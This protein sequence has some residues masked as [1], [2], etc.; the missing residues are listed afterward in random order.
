MGF[1][2]S[3]VL[4]RALVRAATA[5]TL[6]SALLL[7]GCGAEDP[8]DAAAPDETTVPADDPGADGEAADAAAP[9]ANLTDGCVEDVPEGVDLFPEKVTFEHASGVVVTYHDTYKVVE[10]GVPYAEEGTPP[11]T[12]VLLQCGADAPEL[13][14]DLADAQVVEVPTGEIISMTTVNLPHLAA[15]DAVDH[16]AGVG[17]AAFVTTPEVV[18]AIEERGL[19]DHADADGV[20]DRE[21]IVGA[22]PDLLV[23][24]AFGATLLDDVRTFAE[25]GV[26]TVLNADFDEATPLGRAEWIKYTALFLNRE[27]AATEVFADIEAGYAETAALAE[28][29]EDRPRVLL[30]QP[31]EGTWYVPAGGSF[32]PQL[33]ADAGGDYVFAD[34]PGSASV[35]V[36]LEAVLARGGD[37]DVWI[38]AGTA[39][40]TLEDLAAVDGRF[41]EFRAFQEGAVWA[42]A[43]TPAGGYPLYEE[44][45]AR[46]DLVLRDLTAIL[47]PELVEGHEVRFYV[48]LGEAG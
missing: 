8:S 39:G 6:A 3:P 11:F 45:A 26:P 18:A 38:G 37:A 23:L 40:G 7:S 36:D 13:T 4:P 30:E 34:E 35:S 10:V 46:P 43:S 12:V 20:P 16:L 27:A 29:V 28:G 44:G 31:F 33:V 21:R 22:S 15:L 24:D 1:P 41:R 32:V 14:G 9:S 19:A 42:V 25:A 5:T 2:V 17:T 48:R 47:H